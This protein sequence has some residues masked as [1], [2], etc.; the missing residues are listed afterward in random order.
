MRFVCNLSELRN[1]GNFVQTVY[2]TMPSKH[3]LTKESSHKILTGMSY[4][5]IVTTKGQKK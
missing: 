2:K 3:I 5:S 4:S 1:L